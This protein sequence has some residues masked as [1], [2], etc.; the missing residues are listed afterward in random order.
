MVAV[1]EAGVELLTPFQCRADELT[2]DG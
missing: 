1:T 2:I